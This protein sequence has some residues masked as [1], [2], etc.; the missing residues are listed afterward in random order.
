MEKQSPLFWNSSFFSPKGKPNDNGSVCF[1]LLIDPENKTNFAKFSFKLYINMAF[2]S[3]YTTG[4]Q[5]TQIS[6]KTKT[7]KTLIRILK[8]L[9]EGRCVGDH[10]WHCLILMGGRREKIL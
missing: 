8:N 10:T 9:G 3:A 2:I 1:I 5:K 7:K 4:K 6:L